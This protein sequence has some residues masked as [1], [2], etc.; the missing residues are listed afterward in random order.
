MNNE[1]NEPKENKNNEIEF[2]VPD[3]VS[4]DL[5]K[6]LV[7]NKK[8]NKEKRIAEI[9]KRMQ[10]PKT[11]ENMAKAERVIERRVEMGYMTSDYELIDEEE[12][13]YANGTIQAPPNANKPKPSFK[14]FLQSILTDS[15]GDVNDFF[16]E[17]MG[18][19]DTDE[20]CFMI[21]I[22]GRNVIITFSFITNLLD[23][24]EQLTGK[25]LPEKIKAL[26]NK[27]NVSDEEAETIME[28]FA[29]NKKFSEFIINKRLGGN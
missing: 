15:D 21:N 6:N 29:N 26:A 24:Y 22:K 5:L 2:K 27:Q 4:M 18:D 9:L 11:I 16:K 19:D 20:S 1:Q 25:P 3:K 7:S 13:G 8:E 17:L 12:K 23:D 10:L 28:Y 14:Q